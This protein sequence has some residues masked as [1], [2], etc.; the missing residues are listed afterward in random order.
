MHSDWK[1]AAKKVGVKSDDIPDILQALGMDPEH[2]STVLVESFTEACTLIHEGQPI[3]EAV[4]QVIA[5]TEQTQAKEPSMANRDNIKELYPDLEDEQ[6]DIGIEILGI[7]AEQA[8]F[9]AAKLEEF[10]ELQA[11]IA[12][13][14]LD[15]WDEIREHWQQMKSEQQPQPEE[16][17]AIT[18]SQSGVIAAPTTIP[19]DMRDG[20]AAPIIKTIEEDI[21]DVPGKMALAQQSAQSDVMGGLEG[22]VKSTYYQGMQERIQTPEFAERVRK[23]LRSG[24]SRNNSKS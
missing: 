1:K 24:K 16:S 2:P 21:E 23:A 13:G 19:E 22:F 5:S 20:L 15:S 10:Q 9:P 17:E 14:E 4:A 7:P 6:I 8:K 3:E 12:A 11:F 18:V